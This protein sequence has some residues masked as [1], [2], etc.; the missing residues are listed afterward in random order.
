MALKVTK[1]DVW[2][3]ELQDQPGGL[4]NVLAAV[5][6]AGG[7]LSC[8]IARRD[9]SKPGMGEVFVTPVKGT[10]V[11]DAARAAGL[12]P[13]QNVATLC[14]EGPD[15]AGAGSRITEAL[16][17]ARIN[18]R[19]VTTA[20]IGRTFVCYI[21]LDTPSDADAAVAALKQVK[22]GGSSAKKK[23]AKRPVKKK[24]SSK[25]RR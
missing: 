23:A 11:Q 21:G 8:V 4:A 20:V 16:A 15:T 9:Q 18:V 22:M 5:A 1:V 24:A 13:A 6:N 25:K 17:A 2:A 10:R 14:I 19:G 12:S 7:N 3:G